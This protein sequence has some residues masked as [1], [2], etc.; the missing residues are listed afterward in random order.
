MHENIKNEV[1][2][3]NPLSLCGIFFFFSEI[4]PC[5]FVGTLMYSL[6]QPGFLRAL[7]ASHTK[8]GTDIRHQTDRQ[9]DRHTGVCIELIRN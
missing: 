3:R 2:G 4:V 1:A 8:R 5:L 7:V 9:T 6:P